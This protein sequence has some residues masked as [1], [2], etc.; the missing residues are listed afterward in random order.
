MANSEAEQLQSMEQ[1]LAKQEAQMELSSEYEQ[2]APEK[3]KPPKG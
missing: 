3:P 1:D 2:P